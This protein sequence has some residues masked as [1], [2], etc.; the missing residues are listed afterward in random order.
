[1]VFSRWEEVV[2]KHGANLNADDLSDSAVLGNRE[3]GVV[4]YTSV[5]Q[6]YKQGELLSLKDDW[7]IMALYRANRRLKSFILIGRVYRPME[8]K[9][10]QPLRD[11]VSSVQSDCSIVRWTSAMLS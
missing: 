10:Y 5:S 8:H 2:S 9:H 11:T 4:D 7:P 1:M 6:L 3:I